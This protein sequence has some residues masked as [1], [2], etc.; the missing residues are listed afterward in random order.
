[1]PNSTA[2]PAALRTPPPCPSPAAVPKPSLPTSWPPDF[3][4]RHDLVRRLYTGPLLGLTPPH[5]WAPM[6]DEEWAF[7][8]P[9]LPGTANGGAGRPMAEARARLD[10]IFRA[11]TLKR[12]PAEG[13]G[14]APWKA[15][16]PEFGK[17]D[18]ASRTFRRWAKEGL[19]ERLLRLVSDKSG[20]RTP[21][22]AALRY[23]VCCA[24][25]RAI[26]FLGLRG[27]VLARR[28]GLYSA[29]PA[30]SQYLPDP[31]L[32][33]IYVPVI[34]RAL[35]RMQGGPRPDPDG[36]SKPA[37]RPPH[38]AWALFR[39]MHR[40]AGGRARITRAMEPA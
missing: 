39:R 35:D 37:W 40:F 27:I 18:T 32:S 10:A 20:A 12:P 5:P 25:R 29:L 11:V 23:R 13:G 21:L 34:L 30:P 9:L 22:V 36:G 6:T 31:D 1:M 15:L 3:I 38:R 8:R 26:R 4:Q 24:F 19:W 33:E 7:L 14:R 28:L 16:P 17:P 2:P